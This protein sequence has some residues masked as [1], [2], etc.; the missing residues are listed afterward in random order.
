MRCHTD[1]MVDPLGEPERH[2]AT[3][4]QIEHKVWLYLTAF[5]MRRFW[6]LSM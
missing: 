2:L 4:T 5:E 6:L 1:N 3:R